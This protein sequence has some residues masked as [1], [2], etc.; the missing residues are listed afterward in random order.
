MGLTGLEPV[1]LEHSQQIEV[2]DVQ[3]IVIYI[4]FVLFAA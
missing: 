1:T 3:L 4:H 2:A